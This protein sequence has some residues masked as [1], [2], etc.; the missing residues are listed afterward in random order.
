MPADGT[1]YLAV[2]VR[3][4]VS[5]LLVDGAPSAQAFESETDFL[6]L[7][8]S[9]GARPWTVLRTSE[10]DARH[11]A[12]EAAIPDVVILANVPSLTT[13]QVAGLEKLVEKGMGL[14]IF[15]GDQ[16]DAE[17]Y[18]S[19]MFRAGKGLLPAALDR[20]TDTPTAGIAIEKDAQSPL[21]AMGKLLPAALARVRTRQ[22]TTLQIGAANSAMAEGVSV[23]ARWNNA[24][25]PPAVI[26]K[27]FG[28]GRVLLFTTTAGKKW[29]D[30][31]LDPTYVLGMRPAALGIARS[32]EIGGTVEAGEA[33][34]LTFDPGHSVLDPHATTSDAK[35]PEAVDVETSP[36]G[37]TVRYART[38][39]SGIDTLT[40][41][42]EKSKPASAQFAVN[43]PTAESDLEP[44]TDAQL[45]ALMGNLK[46]TVQRYDIRGVGLDAPRAN[47]GAPS[48]PS[49]SVSW[50]PKPPSPH[51]SGGNDEGKHKTQNSKRK[52]KSAA[53]S[54]TALSRGFVF[55]VSRFEFSPNRGSP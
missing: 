21:A 12:S 11:L 51:G 8:Y 53:I 47:S 17:A 29:T 1:R 3:P 37:T 33:L 14:M 49:S 35:T 34:H 18:N 39:H 4:T 36:A 54:D 6:A 28:K 41:R 38:L 42:N 22:Y 5:V 32:Q 45:V 23:L 20:V 19:R 26:E 46:P 15:T 55:C 43:P 16:I 2:T 31:P 50:P 52:T 7:A 24:E 30:W 44:L 48:P 13:D 10:F 9:V 40:W 25:N 27:V